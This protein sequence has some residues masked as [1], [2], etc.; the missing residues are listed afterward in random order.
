MNMSNVLNG[1]AIHLKYA[2]FIQVYIYQETWSYSASSYAKR[3]I[4]LTSF[5]MYYDSF[6]QVYLISD[7][8]G[9]L[10]A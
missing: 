7:S 2:Q 5:C 4:I 6:I 8:F 10:G 1:N 9:A 3:K